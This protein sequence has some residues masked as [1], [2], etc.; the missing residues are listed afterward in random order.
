MIKKIA[1]ICI[2]IYFLF[3]VFTAIFFAANTLE[4]KPPEVNSEG[5]QV[6]HVIKTME[7]SEPKNYIATAYCG[8]INCCGKN[9]RITATGTRA[10]EGRT[11]A[12]DPSVIPYGTKILIDGNY[13]IAED[14]GGAIKGNRVDIYFEEHQ[15]ALEFGVKNI[16]IQIVKEIYCNENHS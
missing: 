5:L 16:Q 7:Y 10:V 14:C 2:V 9:D 13:Y 12:V 11:I 8:C 4:G 3:S 1:Y 15:D 6:V